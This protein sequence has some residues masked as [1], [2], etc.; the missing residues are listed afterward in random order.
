M[1]DIIS[2]SDALKMQEDKN[3]ECLLCATHEKANETITDGVVCPYCGHNHTHFNF[4]NF[5]VVGMANYYDPNQKIGKFIVD[6]CENCNESFA[7]M[8]EKIHYNGNHDVYY[9][10]GKDYLE[11]DENKIFLEAKKRIEKSLK[12]WVDR[13]EKGEKLDPM[14]PALW[15]KRDITHAIASYLFEKGYKK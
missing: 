11:D 1:K 7:L 14:Y 8:P 2:E 6:N 13:Y 4:D 10:G 9:T 12:Q 3:S 5:S 15:I